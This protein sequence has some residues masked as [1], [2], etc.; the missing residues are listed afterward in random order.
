MP[1]LSLAVIHYCHVAAVTLPSNTNCMSFLENHISDMLADEDAAQWSLLQIPWL[2][3]GIEAQLAGSS[4][5][6]INI[7]DMLHPNQ[8]LRE[9]IFGMSGAKQMESGWDLSSFK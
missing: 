7:S 4:L 8:I 6:L 5:P 2:C 3:P 1:Y 9:M